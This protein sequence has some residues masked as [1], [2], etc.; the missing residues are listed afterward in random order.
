MF[1]HCSPPSHVIITMSYWSHGPADQCLCLHASPEDVIDN[2]NLR[3]GSSSKLFQVLTN[4][5]NVVACAPE[6]DTVVTHS[7]IVLG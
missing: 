4:S 2:T 1:R 6:S 3:D 7:K 5:T